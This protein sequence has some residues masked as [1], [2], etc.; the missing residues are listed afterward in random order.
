MDVPVLIQFAGVIVATSTLI[1]GVVKWR[2]T[3]IHGRIKELKEQNEK[4]FDEI[5]REYARQSDI[6]GAIRTM[7]EILK[8]MKIEQHRM[9]QRMDEFI[10]WIM[11]NNKKKE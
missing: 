10:R 5:K 9:A 8:D 7:E 4:R 1:F 3:Q 2:D 6:D 11:E